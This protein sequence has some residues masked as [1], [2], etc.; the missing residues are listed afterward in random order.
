[1]N[2]CFAKIILLCFCLVLLNFLSASR[3]IQQPKVKLPAVHKQ[4]PNC[5]LGFL[6]LVRVYESD[7]ARLT[8]SHVLQYMRYMSYAGASHFFVYDAYERASESLRYDLA[9]I[10]NVAYHDWSHYTPYVFPAT[11]LSAYQHAI[12]HHPCTWHAALDIDEYVVAPDDL[13]P[14]FL[15]RALA[16][17]PTSVAELTVQNY[18]VVGPANFDERHWLAERYKRITKEPGNQLVKPLYKPQYCAAG[19]HHN[20]ILDRSMTSQ[21]ADA[22]H[23]FMAHIWGARLSDFED[24]FSEELRKKTSEFALLS[25]LVQKVK[26]WQN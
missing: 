24:R 3:I 7:K 19:I 9:H 6:L 23:L 16:T 15:Q 21:V 10:P 22:S 8:L 25:E 4:Q 13:E 26:A 14:G 11:Q 5:T 20:T 2:S 1:M 17:V 18:L 12:D